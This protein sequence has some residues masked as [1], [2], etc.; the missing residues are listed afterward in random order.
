MPGALCSSWR[1]SPTTTAMSDSRSE[2][3]R[4]RQPSAPVS[5]RILPNIANVANIAD[6]VIPPHQSIGTISASH[7]AT[8]VTSYRHPL[9][10]VGAASSSSSAASASAESSQGEVVRQESDGQD[11]YTILAFRTKG[12]AVEEHSLLRTLD[13]EVSLSL[14]QPPHELPVHYLTPPGRREDPQPNPYPLRNAHCSLITAHRPILPPPYSQLA[15]AGFAE[16]D[17]ESHRQA[18]EVS[19]SLAHPCSPALACLA[20]IHPLS[21][22]LCFFTSSKSTHPISPHPISPHPMSPHP[23]SPLPKAAQQWCGR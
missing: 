2:Q 10:Y 16:P 21:L 13:L 22:R 7:A 23:M 3:K 20:T 9:P 8:L 12:S 4:V 17:R 11:Y 1:P 18:L 5:Q 19:C 14:T 15:K 6:I